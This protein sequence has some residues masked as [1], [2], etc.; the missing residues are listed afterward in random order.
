MT[1]K[2]PQGILKYHDQAGLILVKAGTTIYDIL[3][4]VRLDGWTLPVV[5]GTGWATVGGCI[6]NDVHGKNHVTR[7]SFGYW[8]RT[9]KVN[10]NVVCPGDN[11]HHAT[12]GGLGLTGEIEYAQLSLV[13]GKPFYPWLFPLDYIPGYWPLYKR[14]GF[15]Q[16][17]CVVPDDA[18]RPL[19]RRVTQRPL[20]LVRKRFGDIPSLGMLS[21][22]RP[23]NSICMDFVRHDERMREQLDDIVHES[24]GALYPAKTNM[25]QRMFRNSFPRWREFERHVV[26]TSDFWRRVSA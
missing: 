26:T 5:P 15:W 20:L 1:R 19:M 24:G 17:H 10:G 22:C 6:A 25:S 7:G 3:N 9:M 13:R 18:V 16:Y 8:V 12:I 14:L 23:G 2:A 4:V 21:F 11:R